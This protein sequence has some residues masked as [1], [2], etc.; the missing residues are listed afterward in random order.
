MS[1]SLLPIGV[2]AILLVLT[3]LVTA[4]KAESGLLALHK[5]LASIKEKLERGPFRDLSAVTQ[6]LQEL[7]ARYELLNKSFMKVL[8]PIRQSAEDIDELDADLERLQKL[9]EELKKRE[10]LNGSPPSAA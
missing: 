4:W 2:V 7:D 8:V 3:V 1:E 6:K 9:Y 5:E 10:E